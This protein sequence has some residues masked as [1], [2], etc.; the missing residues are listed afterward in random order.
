MELSFPTLLGNSEISQSDMDPQP[1]TLD[2][3]AGIEDKH[4]SPRSKRKKPSSD[5]DTETEYPDGEQPPSALP[6][7]SGIE[8]RVIPAAR[9]SSTNRQIQ[10]RRQRR[11][12]HSNEGSLANVS[13]GVTYESPPAKEDT[14]SPASGQ[15]APAPN[16]SYRAVPSV[17]QRGVPSS[18]CWLCR[19]PAY[20]GRQVELLAGFPS[21]GARRWVPDLSGDFIPS[22]PD[23]PSYSL[24]PAMQPAAWQPADTS[25]AQFHIPRFPAGWAGNGQVDD[26]A[27][28]PIGSYDGSDGASYSGS[29]PGIPFPSVSGPLNI[30]AQD[31]RGYGRQPVAEESA[32]A[33]WSFDEGLIGGVNGTFSPDGPVPSNIST[34]WPDMRQTSGN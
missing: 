3:D 4:V 5:T 12:S 26:A 1:M 19:G 18:T 15:H 23:N 14:T 31:M 2:N 33:P 22:T 13:E 10:R 27:M 28:W 25:S 30:H 11:Q 8:T 24:Q 20:P 9:A 29:F 32:P 7:S 6:D 17:S 21:P 34:E 16:P